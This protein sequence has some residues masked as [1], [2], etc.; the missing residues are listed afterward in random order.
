[1]ISSRIDPLSMR[2]E[3]DLTNSKNFRSILG[4]HSEDIKGI[5]YVGELCLQKMMVL[6]G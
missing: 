2:R 1:M 5:Q 3:S 6:N 4:T